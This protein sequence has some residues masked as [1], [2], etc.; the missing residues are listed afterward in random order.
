MLQKRSR[1]R[2]P[3]AQCESLTN[4]QS[5][6]LPPLPPLV[7]LQRK[8]VLAPILY[9]QRY[10]GDLAGAAR[11]VLLHGPPGTGKTSLAKVQAFP[12]FALFEPAAYACRLAEVCGK[13][14]ARSK[15]SAAQH[16]IAGLLMHGPAARCRR[17]LGRAGSASLPFPLTRCSPASWGGA[18][19]GWRRCGAWPRSASPAPSSWVRTRWAEPLRL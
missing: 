5:Q 2:L 15:H 8:S 13:G 16:S 10:R 12:F 18:R 9:P 4:N 11:G 14:P 17:W 19:T 3:E 7:L 1:H 6:Q